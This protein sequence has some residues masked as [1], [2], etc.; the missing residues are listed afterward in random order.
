MG[1][2][3]FFT[4]PVIREF[5]EIAAPMTFVGEHRSGLALRTDA[6]NIAV[7]CYSTVAC[8]RPRIKVRNSFPY[9]ESVLPGGRTFRAAEA[10]FC[11]GVGRFENG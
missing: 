6:A 2:V 5:D 9:W 3:D 10:L 8:Q 4:D 1:T 11:R 7:S